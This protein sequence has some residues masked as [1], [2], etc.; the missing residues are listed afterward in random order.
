VEWSLSSA[1]SVILPQLR[2]KVSGDRSA[3]ALLLFM[4]A[5]QG[6]M[7]WVMDDVKL[8]WHPLRR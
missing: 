6:D 3:T 5:T 8:Q 7:R 1:Y 2:L 4:F